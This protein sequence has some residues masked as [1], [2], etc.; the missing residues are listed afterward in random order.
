MKMS[1]KSII[2]YE[3]IN[4]GRSNKKSI[5]LKPLLYPS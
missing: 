2:K 4:D 1:C 5:L 3:L